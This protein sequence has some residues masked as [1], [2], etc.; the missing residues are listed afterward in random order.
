MADREGSQGRLEPGTMAQRA[1]KRRG[2]GRG[3]PVPEVPAVVDGAPEEEAPEPTGEDIATLGDLPELAGWQVEGGPT[4]E[5]FCKAQ[6]ECPTLEGLRKQ[7]SDQAAGEASGDHHIYWENDLLYS[8]PKVPAFGAARALVVPQYYQTFLL[9]LAHDIPLAGHLGQGKTFDRLV[10][11][12]YWPRMRTNSDKFCRS[13]PTCQASGK[14]GKRV[15][16]PLIPLPVVGT[17]FERVGIDIV[18]PLDPKTALGNKFILV[19]VDHA[20]RYPEAIPL[21]TVT[22]P[23]VTRTLMGIFNRVGFPKEIGPYLYFFSAAFASFFDAKTAQTCKMPL[24]FVG[25]RRFVSKS[26]TNVALKKV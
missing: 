12:F 25:L 6:K 20:T 9:G 2:K 14:A 11:H 4:R 22:A 7:A 21:R 19:L 8:E 26:G 1:A 5:E 23:V 18:G 17:S 24:Y 10:I 16:T 15:K 3:K 13:C